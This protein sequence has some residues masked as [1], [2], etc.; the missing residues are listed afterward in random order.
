MDQLRLCL[1]CKTSAPTHK[2]S[3]GFNLLKTCFECRVFSSVLTFS[4]YAN[5]VSGHQERNK[6]SCHH[7]HVADEANPPPA[8]RARRALEDLNPNVTYN[9]REVESTQACKVR[10]AAVAKERR[11]R[12]HQRHGE[13]PTP[14]PPNSQPAVWSS[15]AAVRSF[16]AAVRSPPTTVQNPAQAA[17]RDSLQEPAV[18]EEHWG[19]I[20]DFY[21]RLPQIKREECTI[22]NEIWYDLKVENGVCNRYHQRAKNNHPPLFTAANH[23]DVGAIPP[24]LPQL[25]QIEEQLIAQVHVHVQVWQIK[26]QQYKYKYHIVNFMQN[27]TKVYKKLPLLVTELDVSC[28]NSVRTLFGKCSGTNLCRLYCS[29]LLLAA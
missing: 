9:R 7:A 16:T 15:T 3:S 8:K 24:H 4:V 21:E 28:S 6:R 14:S 1:A 5:L 11:A 25:T 19:Y 17:A 23:L 22:C 12:N 13:E 10:R 18:S 20:T 29:G 27:T 26:G 2:F